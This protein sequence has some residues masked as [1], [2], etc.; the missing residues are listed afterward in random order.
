MT[1]IVGD[2]L[3]MAGTVEQVQAVED[4]QYKSQRGESCGKV[5]EERDEC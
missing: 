3:G 2:K 4:G 1:G 5:T